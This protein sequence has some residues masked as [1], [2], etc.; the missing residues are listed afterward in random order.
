M[1]FRPGSV[2]VMFEVTVIDGVYDAV[3][4]KNKLN[5]AYY[6]MDNPGYVIKDE[7]TSFIGKYIYFV[8]V[9]W[10]FFSCICKHMLS[11]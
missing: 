11:L 9:Y 1:V 3:T 4:M 5:Q 2:V 7:F 6:S 10:Y 8:C